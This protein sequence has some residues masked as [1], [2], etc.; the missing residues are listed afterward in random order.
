MASQVVDPFAD[1]TRRHFADMVGLGKGTLRM[2]QALTAVSA[3]GMAGFGGWAVLATKRAEDSVQRYVVYADE[4][5][6][7]LSTM[8]VGN[9]AVMPDGAFVDFAQTWIRNLRSR[10]QHVPTLKFQRGQVIRTTDRQL[11]G[12]LQNSMQA[13]DDEL[14][15]NEVDVQEISANLVKREDRVATL[16]VRWTELVKAGNAK[17]RTYTATLTLAY[18]EPKRRKELEINPLGIWAVDFQVTQELKP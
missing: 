16:F 15:T 13:A 11:W 6:N 3:L 12:A 14:K 8:P 9:T 1:R 10:P 7:V 5:M 2:W 4:R 18:Q 17:P